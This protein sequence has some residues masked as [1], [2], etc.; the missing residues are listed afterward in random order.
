MVQTLNK[1]EMQLIDSA[2]NE[3]RTR[4]YNDGDHSTCIDIESIQPYLRRMGNSIKTD[5]ELILCLIPLK[6]VEK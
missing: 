4:C 6:E 2:L 5:Y 3:L 1:F